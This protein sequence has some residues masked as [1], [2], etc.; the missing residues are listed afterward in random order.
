VSVILLVAFVLVGC[1]AILG[2][3]QLVEH[4]LNRRP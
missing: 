2:V 1:A 3:F 4:W